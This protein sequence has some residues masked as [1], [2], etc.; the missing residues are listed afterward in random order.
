MAGRVLNVNTDQ[1]VIYT[2]KLEKMHRSDF[3]LA[4]RS[5]LNSAAFDVKKNTLLKES[6]NVFRNR[7]N[8]GFFRAFSGVDTA[9]GFNMKTMKATAGMIQVGDDEAAGNMPQQESGGEIKRHF[10]PKKEARIGG[11]IKGRQFDEKKISKISKIAPKVKWG[12]KRRF[13]QTINKAGA[14]G[15]VLYGWTLFKIISV[16][17]N[18]AHLEAIHTHKKGR[19][20][21]IKGKGFVRSAGLQSGRKIGD[22]YVAAAKK[23]IAR[24]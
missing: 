7:K 24:L 15:H 18:N 5:A 22:F 10:I 17:R 23:R 16:A 6:R 2:N 13:F 14:G 12:N 1:L 11:T 9:K 21:K 19:R 4:V 20:V 8:R 3:P